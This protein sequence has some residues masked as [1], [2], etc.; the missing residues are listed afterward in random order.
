MID[1]DDEF[2][3]NNVIRGSGK[4]YSSDCFT[5]AMID[6]SCR[7]LPRSV[8]QA[9]TII[10]SCGLRNFECTSWSTQRSHKCGGLHDELTTGADCDKFLDSFEDNYP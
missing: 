1:Y 10:V 4:P 3:V 6:G 5:H 9:D 2:V 7:V 8:L